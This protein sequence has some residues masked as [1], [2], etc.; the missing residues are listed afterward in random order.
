MSKTIEERIKELELTNQLL[1][2]NTIDA[3]WVVD[4]N[5]MTY[6]YI[7]PSIKRIS[8]YSAEEIIGK[9]VKDRMSEKSY[10]H[11]MSLLEVSIAKLSKGDRVSQVLEAELTHKSG[12]PYWVEIHAK[13]FSEKDQS[14][15]IIGITRDITQRKEYEHSQTKLIDKLR[16]VLAE[17]EKLLKENK[18]LQKLLPICS[19]C[20]RIRDEDDRWWPLEYYLQ[21][22]SQSKI[23]HAICG[24]CT[25]VL[26]DSND[27]I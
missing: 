7:T 9:S 8:G 4:V 3:I 1:I 16:S 18:L 27:S 24:D 15:K 17:K 25:D 12:N 2:D 20:R 19:G 13:L 26:Y 6:E 21:H 22:H 14:L 23:S 5:T 10:N 11:I